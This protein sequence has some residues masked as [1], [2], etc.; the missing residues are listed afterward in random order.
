MKPDCETWEVYRS[1]MGTDSPTKYIIQPLFVD[2]HLSIG[3]IVL[4]IAGGRDSVCIAG[5]MT[6]LLSI[7]VDVKTA[8]I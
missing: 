8:S 4:S 7:K 1:R 3:F 6:G 5:G 2:L